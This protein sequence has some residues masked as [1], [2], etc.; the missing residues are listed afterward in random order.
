MFETIRKFFE[1]SRK[2]HGKAGPQG[3]PPCPFCMEWDQF[4]IGP[5][6]YRLHP[7]NGELVTHPVQ[8][9]NCGTRM[10]AHRFINKTK[11]WWAQ[12]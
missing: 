4:D 9:R 11:F 6:T 8:C 12:P 10:I 5:H 2:M 7:Y 1:D 3:L